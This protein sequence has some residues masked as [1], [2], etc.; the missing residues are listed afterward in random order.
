MIN[1]KYNTRS[2][3]ITLVFSIVSSCIYYFSL[4]LKIITHN[5][6]FL[7][8]LK[9]FQYQA[10]HK[11]TNIHENKKPTMTALKSVGEDTHF[12]LPGSCFFPGIL[13]PLSFWHFRNYPLLHPRQ[14]VVLCYLC[15]K[16][17]P[18]RS[19]NQEL[20]AGPLFLLP[21]GQVWGEQAWQAQ[22]LS[23]RRSVTYRQIHYSSTDLP[24]LMMQWGP[25]KSHCKLKIS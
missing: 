24:P 13:F 5:S 12:C 17:S 22:G 10:Q 19:V 3:S 23:S 6:I 8:H 14:G 9:L 18:F 7:S 16:S 25:K 4:H 2:Y 20:A 11:H 15:Y 21:L 1:H